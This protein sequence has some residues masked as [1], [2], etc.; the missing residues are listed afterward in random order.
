[1]EI[2]KAEYGFDTVSIR[3]EC[4]T[5]AHFKRGA[6]VLDIGT[7]SG[8]M[9]IT[10]AMAGL[11]VISVDIS[12]EAIKRARGRI[13][14][15]MKRV[16][17]SIRFVAANGLILPFPNGEFDGVVTFDALHHLAEHSC[18]P[19]IREMRRVCRKGGRLVLS[20]LSE[21][22]M[23]A[24]NEIVARSGEIHECNRCVPSRIPGLLEGEGLTYAIHELGYATAYIV[25]NT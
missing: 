19:A 4:L 25:E 8:W 13:S 12:V 17:T 9:A 21:R 18:P 6:M 10:G 11:R 24:V 5:L 14:T 1:M 3:R 15:M 22:G 20:D 7:G 23:H 2:L 16:D